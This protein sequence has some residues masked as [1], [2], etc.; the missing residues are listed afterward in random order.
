MIARPASSG[1]RS[2]HEGV[3]TQ[4]S[5]GRPSQAGDKPAAAAAAATAPPEAFARDDSGAFDGA[6]QYRLEV[7]RQAER[8]QRAAAEDA[9]RRSRTD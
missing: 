1:H 2:T 6:K 9:A 3:F 7:E 8:A 4:T 5:H